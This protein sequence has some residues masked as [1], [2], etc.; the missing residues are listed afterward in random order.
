MA[1]KTRKRRRRSTG[2]RRVRRAGTK[3]R[4]KSTGVK[5]RV[6]RRR[7]SASGVARRRKS[8]GRRRR[9]STGVKRRVRRRSTGVRR[10]KSTGRRRRRSTRGRQMITVNNGVGFGLGALLGP[11]GL[12]GWL[13]KGNF[14][15]SLGWGG[16]VGTGLYLLGG[17][18]LANMWRR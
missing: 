13:G 11:L 15:N 16:A 14:A 10:R 1:Q 3:R 9:K 4:R 8:T 12:L 7:K 17:V 18:T 6:R 5:R 2:I